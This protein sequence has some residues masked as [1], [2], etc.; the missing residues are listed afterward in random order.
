MKKLSTYLQIFRSHLYHQFFTDEL[1]KLL[2]L[3]Q[4]LCP[5]EQNEG[6]VGAAEHAVD[7]CGK[8][9]IVENQEYMI[10]TGNYVGIT[11]CRSCM[12]E[13]C[14]QANCLGCDRGNYPACKFKSFKRPVPEE[15]AE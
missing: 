12:A 1:F 3:D 4:F 8:P 2:S 6:A 7:V 5:D 14:N 10:S 13:Y 15:A 9:M 11:T